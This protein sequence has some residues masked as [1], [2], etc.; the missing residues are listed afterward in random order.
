MTYW[1]DTER[2]ICPA[3]VH[4]M[5]LAMTG[6]HSV[7]THRHFF[8]TLVISAVLAVTVIF[9]SNSRH[10]ERDI[11]PGELSEKTSQSLSAA[12]VQQLLTVSADEAFEAGLVVSDIGSFVNTKI[13]SVANNELPIPSNGNIAEFEQQAMQPGHSNERFEAIAALGD[14]QDP[15][16]ALM[17]RSFLDDP[18]PSVREEVVE[19]LGALGGATGVA[20]LGY[21]L[22]DDN[23]VVRR[24][25]IETLA[26]LATDDAVAALAWTLDD[27]SSELRE[28]AAD[29]LGDIDSDIAITLLQRFLADNH[30][31]V[32]KIATKHLVRAS[33]NTT[34]AH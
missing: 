19:S 23:V 32:R 16:A 25:A 13:R 24:I 20:G 11:P 17:L 15:L 7:A 8:C 1:T 18:N 21:A 6:E 5:D 10:W 31:R 14:S 2:R 28:L 9:A 30:H 26:E 34:N 22:F 29:E 33:S 12:G 4:D 3:S 27:D